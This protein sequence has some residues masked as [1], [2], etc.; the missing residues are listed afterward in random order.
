MWI[1]FW[2]FNSV[3]WFYISVFMPVP[4]CFDYYSS[5]IYFETRSCD[6]SYFFL[7]QNCKSTC[8][9]VK[10]EMLNKGSFI[11]KALQRLQSFSLASLQ[12]FTYI[13][14]P[15]I[16][17]RNARKYW[18]WVRW[19]WLLIKI[20]LDICPGLPLQELSAFLVSVDNWNCPGLCLSKQYNWRTV[21]PMA[22]HLST[23]GWKILWT[24]EHGW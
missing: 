6:A 19:P 10:L 21:V 17:F 7:S 1:Y 12:V 3:P 11:L 23:L 14:H 24:E 13:I 4:Y 22:T 18:G 20:K 9:E 16:Q 2:L 8:F 5:V 15:T